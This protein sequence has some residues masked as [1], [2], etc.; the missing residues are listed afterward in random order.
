M[1]EKIFLGPADVSENLAPPPL[2]DQHEKDIGQN[3]LRHTGGQGSLKVFHCT[4]R[5]IKRDIGGLTQRRAD[6]IGDANRCRSAVFRQSKA[7]HRLAGTPRNGNR[8]GDIA[9]FDFSGRG[10]LEMSIK[11]NEGR[12]ADKT[13]ASVEGVRD[14]VRAYP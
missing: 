4:G 3:Q 5:G 12:Q 2:S 7:F 11:L 6:G 10:K 9:T 8:N 1:L 13:K 14:R